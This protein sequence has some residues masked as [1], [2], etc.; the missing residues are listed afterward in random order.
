MSSIFFS[1]SVVDLEVFSNQEVVYSLHFKTSPVS[2]GIIEI[3]HLIY[4]LCQCSVPVQ[5]VMLPSWHNVQ[6]MGEFVSFHRPA[7]NIC[8]FANC[9]LCLI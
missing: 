9:L 5:E 2:L 7:V 8:L 6:S 3:L 4:I 1:F